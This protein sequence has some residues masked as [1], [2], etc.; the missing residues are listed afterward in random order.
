[1]RT[2]SFQEKSNRTTVKPAR[3]G[4]RLGISDIL[5]RAKSAAYSLLHYLRYLLVK[6]VPL[7]KFIYV[8]SV[9]QTDLIRKSSLIHFLAYLLPKASVNSTE[10]NN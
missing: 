8:G 7:F 4:T 6:T 1:M 2:G 10:K 9:L 3:R 5:S